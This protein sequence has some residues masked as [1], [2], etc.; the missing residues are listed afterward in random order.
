MCGK[1]QAVI[2]ILAVE[3]LAAC[4][5]PQ[6]AESSA[7]PVRDQKQSTN[8][9]CM[10][11]FSTGEC[12][13]MTW[14]TQ[15]SASNFGAFLFKIYRANLADGTA[16]PIDLTSGELSVVL[17]MPSMGHGHLQKL[18]TGTYLASN[19]FFTMNGE[20][21]INFQT[22]NGPDVTDKATLNFTF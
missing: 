8:S 16:I 5:K 14:Q 1:F 17:W 7:P 6:Y 19:I 3:I 15:P 12:I 20:W 2:L 21:Q 18:D 4:A 11:Q 9:V 10:A 22:K 13:T